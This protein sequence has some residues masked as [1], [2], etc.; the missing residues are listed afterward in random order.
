MLISK[1]TNEA[2]NQQI[3]NEFFASLQDVAVAA[4]FDRESLPELAGHFY[5]QADEERA[6]A[7]RM[8]KFVVD[9]GGSIE[10]PAIKAPSVGF[11]TPERAAKLALDHEIEVT[12]QINQLMDLA[13]KQNDHITRTFLQWFVTEQLE[14]VSSMD[15]L[16]RII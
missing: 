1:E 6:H 8:V 5:L 14:E 3:G 2:L 15:T 10:I 13:E 12:H 11:G 16:H 7:M 9:A 4:H